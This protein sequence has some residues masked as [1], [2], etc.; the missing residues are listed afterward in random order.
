[1][2]RSL[3][4]SALV[5]AGLC[6]GLARTFAYPFPFATVAGTTAYTAFDFASV[7]FGIRRLGA[8]IAWI[9]LLQYYGSPEKPLDKDREFQL[10]WD[11]T[12][13]LFGVRIEKEVCSEPGCLHE[14]HYH[15][16]LEGGVYP[17]FARYCY[18]IIA[19]DPFYYYAYL[20]GGGALA[21]NL[22]RPDEAL[23]LLEHGILVMEKHKRNITRDIHQPYWQ[24][25]LYASAIVYRTSGDFAGMIRLLETA[26][27]QPDAPNMVKSILANIY[28]KQQRYAEAVRLWIEIYDSRD[29]SYR[30][31]A[32]RKINEL[33]KYISSPPR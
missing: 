8:D 22:D 18:R 11:M 13:Y 15:P 29:Q 25:N 23:K 4:F 9:Q 33:R 30:A 26:V 20:Y 16:Q 12:K 32:E 3:I 27:R 1:M 31:N 10:S 24:L 7:V 21:W 14:D 6:A 17:A 19:L 5:A 28:Q 2:V